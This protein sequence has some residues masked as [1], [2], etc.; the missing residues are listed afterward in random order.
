MPM[1]AII[2]RANVGKSTL[3]NKIIEETKAIISAKSGTTRD[4]L[5]G[6]PLWRGKSFSIVD[7]AGMDMPGKGELERNVLRQVERAQKE[8][9]II[10]LLLDVRTGVMQEDRELMKKLLK[11]KK[12]FLV[13]VNKIDNKRSL[14]ELENKEWVNLPVKDFLPVSAKNGSGVGDLLD[15]I[16]E[17]FKKAKIKLKPKEEEETIDIIILGKPNVGKSSLLN[18]LLDKEVAVVSNIAHT[19]REPQDIT[20]KYQDKLIK[21]IDTA[22]IRKKARVERGFEK[23]GV[24]K[25]INTLKQSDIALLIV[26][27]SQ[28]LGSQDKHLASLIYESHKGLIIIAN[29]LDLINHDKEWHKKFTRYIQM[30]FPFLDWAPVLFTSALSGEKVKKIYDTILKVEEARKKTID[31]KTLEYFVKGI[32]MV[33]RPLKAKG[34]NH[35]RILGIKQTGTEPPRFEIAI[36]EKTSIHGSYLKFLSKK[37]REEYGLEGTPIIM[38]TKHIKI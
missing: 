24:R 21:L 12:P 8:A 33:H 1:V 19:T 23:I 27:I 15:A 6:E 36:K 22:G 29:K 4:V 28:A 31:T 37:I 5:Y 14:A 3:F 13:V 32:A 16:F 18:K 34:V 20:L 25:S 30:S 38:E 2:G 17:K 26:D 10:L 11:E 9:D 7:T 35:P